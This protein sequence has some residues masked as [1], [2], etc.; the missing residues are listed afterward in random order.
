MAF[1][2]FLETSDQRELIIMR[3]VSGTGK[4]TRA[5]QLAATGGD[6][7]STDDFF[8]QG[9]D[10]HKNYNPDRLAEAHQWNIARVEQAMEAA[11]SPIIVDNTNIMPYEAKP[12]VLLAKQYGYAIRIEEPQ[13]DHWRQVQN[14]QKQLQ[15]LSSELAGKNLHGAPP[16]RISQMISQYH[17]YGLEDIEKSV[18]PWEAND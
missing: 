14:H 5:R 9:A 12:Y 7:F 15:A 3:G 4:S 8:G 11:R 17:P 1:R 6:I 2:K 18:A 16:D 10:Y 13:S